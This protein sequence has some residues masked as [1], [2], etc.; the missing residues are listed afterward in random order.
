[1]VERS[2]ISKTTFSRRFRRAT[3]YRSMDYV[4]TLRVEEAKEMLET[5]SNAVDHIGSEVGFEDPASFRR[6]FKRKVGLTPSTY[7]RRLSGY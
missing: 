5:I 7:C 1:M 4:H 3:G 6:I 2:G